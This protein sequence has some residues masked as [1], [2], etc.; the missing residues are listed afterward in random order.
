MPY[1]KGKASSYQ[2]LLSQIISYVTD[3]NIHG[4]DAWELKRND[5]WPRGT[6]FRAHGI[7]SNS[8]FYIGLMPLDI[9]PGETYR[10]WLSQPDV[11]GE[12]IIWNPRYLNMLLD[13]SVGNMNATII[14][15]KQTINYT[16]NADIFVNKAH[17]MF[18]G[19]FKQYDDGLNWDEL[20]G[21]MYLDKNVGLM[22][23]H[24]YVGA[25]GSEPSE[26]L[27]EPPIP[28]G[29]GYPA[30]GMDWDYPLSGS[31][32]FWL[33]KDASRLTIITHL[34]NSLGE[35]CWDA[36][37][38]GMLVPYGTEGQKQDYPFPAVVVGPTSGA[39]CYG[40]NDYYRHSSYP[41]NN[42]G[43]RFDYT[44]KN[45]SLVRSVPSYPTAPLDTANAVSQI[46]VHVPNGDWAYVVN[47]I[48]GTQIITVPNYGGG[49]PNYYYAN[50]QPSIQT[51]SPFYLRPT[52]TDLDKTMHVYDTSPPPDDT[53]VNVTYQL[54]PLEIIDAVNG[55]Q[56]MLG[57]IK[58]MYWPS[59]RPAKYGEVI[60]NGKK[61]L[62][63]PNVTENRQWYYP[64]GYTY[65]SDQAALKAQFDTMA[66]KAKSMSGCLIRLE[67]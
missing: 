58:G 14:N 46:M 53:H 23:Q 61:C 48:Q 4:E 60:V 63:L 20:P 45:T 38:V 11:M 34:V 42:I 52:I 25:A 12:R 37:H 54:E 35:E 2:D 1:M 9:I 29:I 24:S 39:V 43:I 49:Y 56:N 33:V 66:A 8:H 50:A 32:E 30:F 28:P 7:K 15:G 6:I 64:H 44:Y 47:W 62:M 13:F 27:I 18:L 19:A 65:I 26:M 16:I 31:F 36:G 57:H 59:I 22:K 5:P 67:E 41:F 17:A 10:N 51:A 40:M 21:G 55:Y 3:T